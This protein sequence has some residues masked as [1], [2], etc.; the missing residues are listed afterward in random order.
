[1]GLDVTRGGLE[2]GG[3]LIQRAINMDVSK[4]PTLE[5]GLMVS[6]MIVS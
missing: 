4:F 6:G 1:M 2:T 5:A 3:T